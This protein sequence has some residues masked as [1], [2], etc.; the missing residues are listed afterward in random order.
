[1]EVHIA[2]LCRLESQAN[3][4]Q[5][6]ANLFKAIGRARG[7]PEASGMKLS[8]RQPFSPRRLGLATPSLAP[9][10]KDTSWLVI[11][12]GTQTD[13]VATTL[14]TASVHVAFNDGE[15]VPPI[16]WNPLLLADRP[17][18]LLQLIDW[19]MDELQTFTFQD[20]WD[21]LI[22]SGNSCQNARRFPSSSSPPPMR[23]GCH[24]FFPPIRVQSFSHPSVPLKW[25]AKHPTNTLPPAKRRF[26][27]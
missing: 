25:Q 16:N 17:K 21:Y 24:S 9:H 8:S 11:G 23:S 1:M 27:S 20:S 18:D 7:A 10:L 15:C 14:P 2:L 5:A 13:E 6:G 4:G 12:S 19:S 26:P 3:L 22:R